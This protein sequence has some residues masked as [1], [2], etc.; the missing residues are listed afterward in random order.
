VGQP[1][2]EKHLKTPL[3]HPETALLLAMALAV[4]AVWSVISVM[5]NVA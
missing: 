4:L 3:T 1:L 2:K 5:H